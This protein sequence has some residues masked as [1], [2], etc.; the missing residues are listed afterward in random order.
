MKRANCED[1]IIMISALNSMNLF[2]FIIHC[3]QYSKRVA[4]LKR[5]DY[6][7]GF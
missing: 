4:L 5:C 3:F 1:Q 6:L 7:F 2:K